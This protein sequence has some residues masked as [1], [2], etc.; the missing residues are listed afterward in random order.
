[1]IGN[2]YRNDASDSSA[3]N[4]IN[5]FTYLK[6]EPKSF[7]I[8]PINAELSKIEAKIAVVVDFP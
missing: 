5:L 2:R 8:A 7:E 3:S 4:A 6:L 1:M